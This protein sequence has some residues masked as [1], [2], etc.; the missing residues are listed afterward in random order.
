MFRFRSFC[1]AL[2]VVSAYCGIALGV[3]LDSILINTSCGWVNN[4]P[5]SSPY[6]LNIDVMTSDPSVKGIRIFTPS[7]SGVTAIDLSAYGNDWEY[8]SPYNYATLS[9][10]QA[11]YNSGTWSVQ[12]LGDGAA[13]IDTA[14]LSYNPVA[15]S[16]VPIITSPAADAT[17]VALTPTFTWNP[18]GCTGDALSMHIQPVNGDDLYSLLADLLATQWTPGQLDPSKAY[19]FHIGNYTAPGISIVDG[20]PQGAILSTSAGS[21]FMYL[22]VCGNE[23]DVTFTTVPEPNMLLLLLIGGIALVFRRFYGMRRSAVIPLR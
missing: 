4:V 3:T 6:A 17:G 10:L 15:P 1:L 18:D 20:Q 13:I 19:E 8:H 14:S 22:P 5:Q 21:N 7:G 11:Q 9:E 16:G 12:F 2:I 23:N